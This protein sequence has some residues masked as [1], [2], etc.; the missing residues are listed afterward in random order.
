MGFESGSISLRMFYMDSALPS[1]YIARVAAQAAPPLDTLGRDSIQGWVT[2]R[3][4]LD[5]RITEDS[6]MVAGYLRLTLMK[7]ERKIPEA[8]L[9]AECVMEEL[10]E[11]QARGGQFLKREARME[12]R[13]N[14]MERLMPTMPPTLKGI[15][16]VCDLNEKMVYA[17][18]LGDKQMDALVIAFKQATGVGLVPVTPEAAAWQRRKVQ[19]ADL[20]PTSFSPECDDEL[21]SANLGQD[22]LTWLWFFAEMRGGLLATTGGEF[23]LMVGGPLVF[24][25]EGDGAHETVL[26][27][28][29]PMVSAEAKTSLLSGKKL[30]RAMLMLARGEEMWTVTVDAQDFV[31]RGLKMPQG[32]QLEPVSRFQERMVLLSLFRDAYLQWFDLFLSERTDKARWKKTRAEMQA[33]VSGRDSRR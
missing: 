33:W 15:P 21:V 29:A 13:R 23:G 27:K 4:L 24:V 3:H 11:I 1:K 5:R 19:A 28:G 30:S 8:L 25:M 22:F 20:G 16:M 10:A 7:A 31:F 2:G 12:I 17:A 9:R 14:V 6:A 26:R 32:E 18:A